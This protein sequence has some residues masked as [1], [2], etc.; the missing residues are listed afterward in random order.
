MTTTALYYVSILLVS[1]LF[2]SPLSTDNISSQRKVEEQSLQVS[3][4]SWGVL[5][6]VFLLY[7]L[8][9]VCTRILS[10]LLLEWYIPAH[11]HAHKL[12]EQ[13]SVGL[14]WILRYS[15]KLSFMPL[16]AIARLF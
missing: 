1:S 14:L 15:G 6:Y 9:D 11:S 13:D 8:V 4:G 10:Q 7:V 16:A 2:F 12:K 3:Y 5:V